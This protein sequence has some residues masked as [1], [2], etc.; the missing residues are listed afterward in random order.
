MENTT[1]NWK[2]KRWLATLL[3]LL[4]SYFGM[5]YIG[6]A[7]WFWIYLFALIALST[8]ANFTIYTI[9]LFELINLINLTLSIICAIHTFRLCTNFAL[10][11]T[12]RLQDRG[13]AAGGA[14]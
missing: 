10:I 3:S 5:L 7:K 4:L 9:P 13:I 8:I 1:Q 11:L 2:P 14:Y 6:K 12:L